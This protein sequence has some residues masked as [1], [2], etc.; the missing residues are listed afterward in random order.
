MHD[1]NTMLI[2]IRF[3]PHT[4]NLTVENNS[5]TG[6][7]GC[8]FESHFFIKA[9]RTIKIRPLT[10]IPDQCPMYDRL[11]HRIYMYI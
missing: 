4:Y 2:K 10:N 7:R 1:A 6:K 3:V 8:G 9:S 11:R 5:M